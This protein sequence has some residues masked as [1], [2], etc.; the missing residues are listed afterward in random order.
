MQ[1]TCIRGD[2]KDAPNEND[3]FLS[4]LLGAFVSGYELVSRA[5]VRVRLCKSSF[6]SLHYRF[7]T[8]ILSFLESPYPLVQLATGRSNNSGK[9]NGLQF[10]SRTCTQFRPR[11]EGEW[12]GG[13]GG[14]GQ[15][16]T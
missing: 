9:E 16:Q 11:R 4:A 2:Y 12:W 10:Q 15:N 8:P 13:G 7:V 3:D 14:R 6:C 1:V 5:G